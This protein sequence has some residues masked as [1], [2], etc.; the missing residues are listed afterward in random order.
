MS[1]YPLAEYI[2]LKRLTGGSETSQYPEER[3]SNE[4]LLVAAS[5][6]GIAQTVVFRHSGVVGLPSS[7]SELDRRTGWEAWPQRVKASYLKS[8]LTLAVPEYRGTRETPWESGRTIF[9]G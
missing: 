2:G 7:D 4:T 5:E 8:N 6:R 9:Q 3:K 1:R